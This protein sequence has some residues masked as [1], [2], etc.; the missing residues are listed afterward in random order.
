MRHCLITGGSSGIGFALA[1]LLLAQGNKVSL[2][3]RD[4][5]KLEAAKH[6]LALQADDAQRIHIASAD[7]VDEASLR[8]AFSACEEAFGPVETVIASA[9]IVTPQLF[10]EQDAAQF[11]R[12]V[13]VNLIGVANTMRLALP[14]MRAAGRGRVLIIASGA[15]LVS[16][17]GYS[18]YCASKAALRSFAT[19]LRLEYKGEGIEVCSCFPP[20]TITPQ[21][22]EELTVRPVEAR[23]FIGQHEPWAVDLVAKRILSGMTKGRSEIHFGLMLSVL[24]FFEPILRPLVHFAYF[25]RAPKKSRDG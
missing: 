4:W 20:D 8:D 21:L 18:A 5:Q 2:V 12:Q 25:R 22:M 11:N 23:R 16:I 3:A 14:T 15:G 17:P 13:A 7:V 6:N 19:S 10:A 1:R 9:G 24:A